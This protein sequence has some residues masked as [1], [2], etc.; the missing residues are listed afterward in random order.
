MKFE[1]IS[2][3]T[4]FRLLRGNSDLFGVILSYLGAEDLCKLALVCRHLLEDSM[5][6][7]LWKAIIATDFVPSEYEGNALTKAGYIKQYNMMIQRVNR[8]K[9]EK[10]QIAQDSEREEK[11]Y[12]LEKFLDLTQMRIMTCLPPFCIFLTILLLSLRF[13]GNKNISSWVCFVPILLF[14]VYVLINIA[15][16][17][18]MYEHQY[19]QI[20][21]MR[22]LW[23][24]MSGPIKYVYTEMLS[25]SSYGV[26]IAIGLILVVV[27]EV[28]LLS[29][30]LSGGEDS[31]SNTKIPWGVV[32]IPL[33]CMFFS[34]MLSP[35]LGCFR[36]MGVYYI[37]MT[38]FWLP[39]F[40]FFVCLTIK[41]SGEDVNDETQE[42]KL[43]AIFV[44]LWLIEGII[45]LATLGFLV[46]GAV[47]YCQGNLERLDEHLSLFTLCWG[48]FMPL[49]IFEILMCI[50]DEYGNI[51]AIDTCSPLLVLF[52]GL[53]FFA[54]VYAYKYKSP[55][56]VQ[57]ETSRDEEVGS[58]LLYRI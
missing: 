42:L 20:S 26:N 36:E 30:K 37:C 24:Q 45:M 16:A 39:L 47:K 34:F 6:A 38:L 35:L 8:A 4:G 28:F 33:W 31:L 53:F 13:D 58:R 9:I 27:I 54:V 50:R 17:C 57:R 3:G 18:F 1:I 41:L 44:P 43:S 10:I 49:V 32:F 29:A 14:L 48:F 12:L 51:K 7:H 56:D 40:I 25:Q 11:I 5:T 23:P 19:S 52:L 22:G 46:H 55:F 15:V 2:R 21:I